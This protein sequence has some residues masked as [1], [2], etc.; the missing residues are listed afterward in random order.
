MKKISIF[1]G[2]CVMLLSLG[3]YVLSA[4]NI[5]QKVKEMM[6]PLDKSFIQSGIFIQQAPLFIHPGIYDG[7]NTNDTI[8]ATIQN[9]GLLYAQLRAAAIGNSFLPDTAIYI[10]T[11]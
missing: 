9:W 8:A 7:K 11:L 6:D 3:C 10:M 5:E 1:K 4:Q 2:I